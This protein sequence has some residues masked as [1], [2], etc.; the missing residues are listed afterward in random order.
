[1]SENNYRQIMYEEDIHY[2]TFLNDKYKNNPSPSL[3]NDKVI[4]D[5]EKNNINCVYKSVNIVYNTKIYEEDMYN[6]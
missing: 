5:I 1:M 2:K 6:I 3:I 4:N